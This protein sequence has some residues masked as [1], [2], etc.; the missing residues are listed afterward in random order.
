MISLAAH[1]LALEWWHR[2]YGLTPPEAVYYAWMNYQ[3]AAETYLGRQPWAPAGRPE[4]LAAE[5]GR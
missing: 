5:E 1:T 2:D 3:L 4:A